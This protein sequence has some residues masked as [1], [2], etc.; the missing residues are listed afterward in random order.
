MIIE[1][2]GAKNSQVKSAGE[3]ITRLELSLPLAICLGLGAKGCE[4][5]LETTASR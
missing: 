3:V 1:D 4:S 5:I 2:G